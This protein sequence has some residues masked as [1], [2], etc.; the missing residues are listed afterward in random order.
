MNSSDQAYIDILQGRL[1]GIDDELNELNSKKRTIF[2]HDS[3]LDKRILALNIEKQK[4]QDEITAYTASSRV[5]LGTAG[6]K[7]IA[8][9]EKRF[10]DNEAKQQEAQDAINDLNSKL[11]TVTTRTAKR[12]ISKQIE[13]KQ[14]ELEK[15]QKKGA[16]IQKNQRR[17]L[18]PKYISIHRKQNKVNRAEA[19]VQYNQQKLDDNTI[20]KSAIDDKALF[21]GVR[22][23]YYDIKGVFYQKNLDRSQ[24]HLNRLNN[25]TA[26][27]RVRGAR[28][29]NLGRNMVN[30]FKNRVNRAFGAP[31][32]APMTP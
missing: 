28:V 24:R 6:E 15:L 22:E 8:G 7:V 26:T 25:R 32:F 5:H 11:G 1:Q 10:T 17:L 29:M 9:Y 27:P 2:T 20:L 23:K 3:S 14:K 13:S 16:K 4:I 18:L 12:K 19:V 31:V 30:N 21:K